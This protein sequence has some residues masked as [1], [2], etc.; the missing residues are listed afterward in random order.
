MTQRE[1]SIAFQTDKR[2]ADYIAL[3]KLVDDY[4]FDA[5]TV[6]CDAPY[7]PSFGPLL[8]MAP[9]IERAR[10][11]PAG[12]SPS[13]MHPLDIAA[14]AALLAD[15]A[16]AGVY[17]GLVRGGWLADHGIRELKPPLTAMRES[18][19]IIRKLLAGEAAGIDGRVFQIAEHVRA[20]YP[21]PKRRI[22]LQVGTW[23][24]QMAAL[25]GELADEVKIGGSANP[26]LIA[27]MAEQIARGEERANRPRGTVKIV[28]GAVSV[29][30][31]D[32]QAARWMARKAVALYLPIVSKL[33]P[34]TEIELELMRRVQVAVNAGDA[35]GAARLVPDEI[36]DR[37]AFA[38]D[39]ADIIQQCERLFDAGAQRIELGTP[40]GVANS[41]RGIRLIGGQ[42]LS[43][44]ASDFS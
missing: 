22:P 25:A 10:I 33:D 11:G 7:H 42:V 3:A 20:P 21:L 38:G 30:D 40:H 32:R 6:Y 41:A 1:I 27:W 13:R 16:R 35:E 19:H 23:G 18:I 17:L 9:Y 44:L 31:D 24:A 39:V 37:F 14:G 15:V 29:V 26:A 4:A 8:L 28:I 5:V 34:T 2:A 36:L 12:I 43:A